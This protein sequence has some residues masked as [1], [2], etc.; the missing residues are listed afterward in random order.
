M[1]FYIGAPVLVVTL[2]L[3][4]GLVWWATRTP[5]PAPLA[6]GPAVTA[7]APGLATPLVAVA[8]PGLAA[9]TAPIVARPGTGLPAIP[10]PAAPPDPA[11]PAAT[12]APPDLDHSAPPAAAPTPSAAPPV[13]PPPARIGSAKALGKFLTKRCLHTNTL[14]VS[15][16]FE[17]RW[18]A[19]EHGAIVPG[20]VRSKD[21]DIKG[22]IECALEQTRTS[23]FSWRPGARY[24]EILTLGKPKPAPVEPPP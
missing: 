11:I 20:S 8:P 3:I 24:K 19:D 14:G 1:R 18:E 10:P 23:D 7:G 4:V 12:A 16:T 15:Q 9:P 13:A 6:A 17:M 2:A 5:A 22:I 21:S